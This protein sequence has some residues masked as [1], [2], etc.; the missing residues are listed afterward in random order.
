MKIT[1]RNLSAEEAQ[2][3]M[4]EGVVVETRVP[5]YYHVCSTGTYMMMT[6][7]FSKQSIKKDATDDDKPL[8]QSD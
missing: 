3:L 2:K 5:G 1:I 4:D 8:A 7:P 6:G